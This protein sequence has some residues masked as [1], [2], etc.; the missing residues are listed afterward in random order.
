MRPER[1]IEALR[2]PAGI[3]KHAV[4]QEYVDPAG[5]GESPIVTFLQR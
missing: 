5:G 2:L 3:V 4:W 1:T